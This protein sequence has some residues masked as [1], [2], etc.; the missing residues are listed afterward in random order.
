[1]CILH[2]EEL[3]SLKFAAKESEFFER[4][5]MKHKIFCCIFLFANFAFAQTQMIERVVEGTSTQSTPQAAKKDIVDQAIQKMTEEVIKDLIGEQKFQKNRTVIFQKVIRNSEAFIPF[6]KMGEL[7]QVSEKEFKMNVSLK[8]SLDGLK[9]AL[10]SQGLLYETDNLPTVISFVNV[11]DRNN[12]DE[13]NWWTTQASND[14]Q[15]LLSN[16]HQN[17]ETKMSQSLWKNNFYL[18][19]AQKNQLNQV[20]P[21]PFR[22]KEIKLSDLNQLG[23]Y[24]N[25]QILIQGELSYQKSKSLED[26]QEIELKL[27]AYQV[28]NERIIADV[29]RKFTTDKGS[30]VQAL[31]EKKLS[32]VLE[33]ATL[34]LSNQLQETWARGTLGARLVR[35]E[36]K[37]KVIPS[38][39]EALK[40]EF[41]QIPQIKNIRERLI[42]SDELIF[43]VETNGTLEEL[44][45]KIKGQSFQKARLTYLNQNDKS[46][47]FGVQFNQ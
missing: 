36:L 14:A 2:L 19:E 30:N 13:F 23:P 43:E 37:G 8:L 22:K 9:Q 39:S 7:Q 5:F 32:Q 18:M 45:Q 41:K 31:V 46:L 29:A 1:M 35:L 20:L 11:V 40:N 6:T 42:S 12:R 28:N 33:Q 34:D 21:N 4:I 26:A 10:L 47:I 24:L 15:K 17:F 44:S 25:A 16:I 27:T 38:L 3:T